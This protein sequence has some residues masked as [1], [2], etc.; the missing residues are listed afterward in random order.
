MKKLP[1]FDDLEAE[2]RALVHAEGFRSPMEALW[3]LVTWPALDRAAQL[4]IR[5]SERFDGDNYELLTRAAD[6][7][8]S[9][10]PLAATLVLRAM[11]DFCLSNS[12]SSRYKHA[13]RHLLECSSLAKDVGDFGSFE[14]H[15][16]YEARLKREHGRKASFWSLM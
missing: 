8:S 9:K 10:H 7:L 2:E 12:R 5:H 15:D 16:T 1:D 3:F 13:A 4:V 6:T 11:I 14:P